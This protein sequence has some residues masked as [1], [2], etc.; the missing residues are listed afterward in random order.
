MATA[1]ANIQALTAARFEMPAKFTQ[2]CE[3][4]GQPLGGY[5]GGQSVPRLDERHVRNR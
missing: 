1:H 5:I 3:N 2:F 4:G